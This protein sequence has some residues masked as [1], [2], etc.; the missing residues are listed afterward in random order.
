LER[1]E[2]GTRVAVE[3][4]FPPERKF[5]VFFVTHDVL[6]FHVH[7]AA[8]GTVLESD[9]DHLRLILKAERRK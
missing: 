7:R 1:N 5:W 2:H 4:H 8:D 9:S 6:S 3:I